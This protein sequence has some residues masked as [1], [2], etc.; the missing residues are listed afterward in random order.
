MPEL[1]E[2][3][4]IRRYLSRLAVGRTVARVDVLREASLKGQGAEEFRRLVEGRTVAGTRRRGKVLI[5]ELSG[6]LS[7]VF[8]LGMSGRLICQEGEESRG[9]H[10]RVVF[11]WEGGGRMVFHDLRAFGRVRALP[12]DRVE[13]EA[14]LHALGFEPLESDFT[15]ERLKEALGETRTPIKVALL[16][17]S[18][19]SG[20]GNIYANEILYR[21]GV[22]PARRVQSLSRTEWRK[23]AQAIKR[24]L[25][26]AIEAEGSSISDYLRPDG[27][28]GRFQEMLRVYGRE[29]KPCRRC[30]SAIVRIRQ[31]GRSTFFCPSCQPE[32]AEQGV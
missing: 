6:G 3:E 15:W 27:S 19:V 25:T 5:L 1:P 26:S 32:R 22:H 31:G 17:Q 4:T 16:D 29:G 7:M 14:N 21:S 30:G 10:D 9:K 8:R 11:H 23:M 20:I 13:E 24:V 18:R 2:V 12:S 28:A